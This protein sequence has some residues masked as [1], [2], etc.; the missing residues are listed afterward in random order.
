MPVLINKQIFNVKLSVILQA[1]GKKNL[2]RV[3][4]HPNLYVFQS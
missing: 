2:Y 4:L 3:E 1:Q